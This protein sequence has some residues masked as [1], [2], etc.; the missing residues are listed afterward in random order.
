LLEKIVVE[1][2]LRSMLLQELFV[3]GVFL[4]MTQDVASVTD[5]LGFTGRSFTIILFISEDFLGQ[6]ISFLLLCD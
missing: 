4:G 5:G 1:K 2:V 6:L 3:F